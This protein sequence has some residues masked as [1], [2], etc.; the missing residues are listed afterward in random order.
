[1]NRTPIVVAKYYAI[2]RE[3]AQQQNWGRY[4]WVYVGQYE[5]L[6][7]YRGDIYVAGNLDLEWNPFL[8]EHLAI[9]SKLNR[10][11]LIYVNS[12]QSDEDRSLIYTL[13]VDICREMRRIDAEAKKD[14][15]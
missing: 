3:Y 13:A 7:G 5:K 9:F 14:A 6:L 12:N 1:M 8:L 2:A 11:D 15:K 4:A 10:L